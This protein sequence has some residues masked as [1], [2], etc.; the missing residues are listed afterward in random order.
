[1]CVSGFAFWFIVFWCA[2]FFA[3]TVDDG[4]EYRKDFKKYFMT[5]T[6]WKTTLTGLLTGLVPILY[7]LIDAFNSG[8]FTGK[9]TAECMVGAGVIVL[10]YLA[11]DGD[12]TGLPAS[13]VSGQSSVVSSQPNSGSLNP[14]VTAQITWCRFYKRLP[15]SL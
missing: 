3:E 1:M 9:S 6:S 8:A 7:A 11:K 5:N 15:Q 12:K 4:G 2:G 10:G 14:V 13:V